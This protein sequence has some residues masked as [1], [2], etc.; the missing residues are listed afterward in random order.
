[1]VAVAIGN[2]VCIA[3]STMKMEE[4]GSSKIFVPLSRTTRCHI[5]ETSNLIVHS[6]KNHGSHIEEL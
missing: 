1:V 5:T 2:G 4:A 6:N 3:F